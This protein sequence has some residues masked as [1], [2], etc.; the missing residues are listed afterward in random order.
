MKRL[1]ILGFSLVTLGANQLSV[2]A[3]PDPVFKPVIN[4]I[5][6]RLPA[7]LAFRLPANLPKSVTQ[8]ISKNNLKLTLESNN[9]SI[10]LRVQDGSKYCQELPHGRTYALECNRFSIHVGSLSS[11]FYK[12]SEKSRSPENS[13]NLYKNIKAYLFAGDEWNTLSWVQNGIYFQIYS[14]CPKDELITIAKSMAN[15]NPIKARR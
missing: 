6:Q 15:E 5:K 13:F 3:A 2:L 7:N 9:Q 10:V 12:D 8:G 11:A 1:F 4:Q 14:S